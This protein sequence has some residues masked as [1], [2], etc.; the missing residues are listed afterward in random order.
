MVLTAAQ[1]CLSFELLGPAG[2]IEISVTVQLTLKNPF[3]SQLLCLQLL[4][5][6]PS[7][8]PAFHSHLTHITVYSSQHSP[9]LGKNHLI[10]QK[11]ISI[12]NRRK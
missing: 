6:H 7:Q 10:H 5:P 4:P 2:L 1:H 11:V 3:L 12:S 9:A 8:R